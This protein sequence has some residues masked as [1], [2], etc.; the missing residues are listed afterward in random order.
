MT[1]GWGRKTTSSRLPSNKKPQ[2]LPEPQP[3]NSLFL[4]P[5]QY[6]FPRNFPLNDPWV[7]LSRNNPSTTVQLH[8]VH[9][10][11][12]PILNNTPHLLFRCM[13]VRAEVY[14]KPKRRP[15]HPLECSV[16]AACP[17]DLTLMSQ[18]ACKN[19][20][21]SLDHPDGIVKGK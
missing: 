6:S 16:Y 8:D 10:L 19:T 12:Q 17:L 4:I 15:S 9:S 5:P 13:T 20:V 11:I 14:S 21:S 2:Y 3:R 18:Q 1:I 7:S